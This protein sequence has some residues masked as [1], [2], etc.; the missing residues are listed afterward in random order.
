M[1]DIT[2]NIEIMGDDIR[3]SD[4]SEDGEPIRYDCAMVITFGSR[5]ELV[6]ALNGEPV[7]LGFGEWQE[8]KADGGAQSK[9]QGE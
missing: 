4:L 2:A 6:A 8:G 5:D 9:T 7:R 1:P 3:V